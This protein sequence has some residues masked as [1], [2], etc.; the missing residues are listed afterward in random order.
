M[1]SII[2]VIL[3]GGCGTRLWPL[4]RNSFPKQYLSLL[5]NTNNSLLQETYKRLI[6][7]KNIHEPLIICNEEHRFI[8]AEQLREI[9]I[10]PK[11]ILLEP[12]A[13]NT[14][15]AIALAAIKSIELVDDPILLVLSSDHKIKDSKEFRKA[16]ERGT[17]DAIKGKLVVFGT[18][19]DAPETGYGYI[20]A[21]SHLRDSKNFSSDIE[22]FIEKPIKSKAEQFILDK[23]YMWN[24]GIF[25]FKAKT[26]LKELQKFSPEILE[27][28]EKALMFD[29][30]DLDFQR[31]DKNHFSKCKEISIDYA[32]ME[33]TSLGRVI[34]LNAGWSDLGSWESI[35]KNSKKDN[36]GNVVSG[37][38][39]NRSCSNCYLKGEETLIVGLGLKNL[40]AIESKDAIL[41]ADKNST[42]EIKD[43][44]NDLKI[45][46]ISQGIYHKKIYRPWGYYISIAEGKGW[47]VKEILVKPSS[48]L[49]LQLHKFRSEHWVVVNGQAKVQIDKE[50]S[51]LKKNESLFVPIKKKHRLSNP[52]SEPLIIIEVQIGEYIEEDD[53]IRFND[54]YGRVENN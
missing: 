18:T 29:N 25:L 39:I 53:I 13:R 9:D 27:N 40:I 48:S 47:K 26:I 46:N 4:S 10:K 41:I 14:A 52:Y 7:L 45:N 19:P 12:V 49:S 32:V 31:I 50:I 33:K 8:V 35:W 15:P 30:N 3:S 6:G 34:E 20:K 28:C 44:V 11:A 17:S 24:S 2:P 43:V 37:N 1:N 16:I 21:K 22:K 5:S 51:V 36:Q 54:I 23:R 42:Q 38:I